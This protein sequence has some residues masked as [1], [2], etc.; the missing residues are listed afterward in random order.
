MK[1][2][3][4]KDVVQGGRVKQ[5]RRGG[6]RERSSPDGTPLTPE[7]LPNQN[8]VDTDFVRGAEVQVSEATGKKWIDQGLAEEVKAAPKESA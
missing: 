1:V 3:L 7:Y 5:S 8:H 6:L 2:K 4:L